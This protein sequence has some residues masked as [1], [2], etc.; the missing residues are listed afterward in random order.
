MDLI[1][2]A[3]QPLNIGQQGVQIM[4]G[5]GRL[6]AQVAQ[7]T[8]DGFE[9]VHP[10][11][12]AGNQ[13]GRLFGSQAAQDGAN[14]DRGNIQLDLSDFG[15]REPAQFPIH[16]CDCPRKLRPDG[17]RPFEVSEHFQ[18]T[19][20]GDFIQARFNVRFAAE[21]LDIAQ[22]ARGLDIARQF[23]AGHIRIRP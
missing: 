1:D 6:R 3:G 19:G 2:H 13:I 17:L 14:G 15:C 10:F 7:A 18:G 21:G 8:V 4:G 16:D 5:D 23:V 9:R 11:K 20:D 22:T 12:A